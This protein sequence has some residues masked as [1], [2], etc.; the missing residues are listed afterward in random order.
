M[1]LP[2]H[3]PL[4][5]AELVWFDLTVGI[6]TAWSVLRR[7]L[8]VTATLRVMARVILGSLRDPLRHLP[9]EGWPPVQEALVRHQLRAVVRLDDAL[10]PELTE[11]ARVELLR[12]V[13]ARTGARFLERMLK[14]PDR[15]AWEAADA[16][17]RRTFVDEATTRFCNAVTQN[18]L[19][20][21]DGLSFEVSAC[22]FVPLTAQLDRA[23]LAP[24][25]CAADSERFD[26]PTSLVKLRRA[27]TLATG[28]DV[29][30]FRFEFVP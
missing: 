6:R 29:C 17:A 24:L 1:A 25:F 13:V 19:A 27:G 18:H 7:R 9:T 28:S 30:D 11:V 3:Q 10:R 21:D 2:R 23:Y 4:T 26:E 5:R 22:R 16:Q 12:D 15:V 14:L 8:S 20:E